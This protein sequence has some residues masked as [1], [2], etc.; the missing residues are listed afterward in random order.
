MRT[1]S[2]SA[3][4][5]MTLIESLVALAIVSMMLVSVWTSFSTT[6]TAMESTEKLQDRYSM[7]RN[8]MD[9][10]ATEISMAYLSFNR[11]RG[12]TKQYTFF[13]GRHEGESD[14]L[15][16]STYAHLRVRKD[17]N[18]S[19]QSIIQYVVEDDPEDSKRKHLY[20]RETK[21]LTGDLPEMVYRFA[22][23]YVLC[24]DVESLE[25]RYWDPTRLEWLDEWRTTAL[26]AQPDRLP[27]RV[28]IKLGF[29]DEADE[30]VY[31]VTQVALP[32]QEKIDLEK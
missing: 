14:S 1:S 29:Y 11:P 4:R 26:D 6:V 12:E 21:R 5:G 19:D 28:E 16:F 24:E 8:S 2:R 18:E 15:T 17:A 27:T 7:L 32:M 13:E 3:S 9:R 31:F 30:L 10:M 22:P 25:L 23:A 20:R